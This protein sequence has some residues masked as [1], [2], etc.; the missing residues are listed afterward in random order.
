MEDCDGRVEM[1]EDHDERVE[2]LLG[3]VFRGL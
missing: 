3:G 1:L 2:E